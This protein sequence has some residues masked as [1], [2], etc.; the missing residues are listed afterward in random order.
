MIHSLNL[1]RACWATKYAGGYP[2]IDILTSKPLVVWCEG[3]IY[4]GHYHVNGY[5]YL[6]TNDVC[7]H[8]LDHCTYNHS[9]VVYWCYQ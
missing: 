3:K 6:Y 5:F 4:T 2:C 8:V 7:V 1:T 9:G